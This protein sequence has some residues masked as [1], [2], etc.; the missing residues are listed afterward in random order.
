MKPIVLIIGLLVVGCGKQEQTTTE[1]PVK[2][3]TAEEKKVV[4]TY[5]H[6][7]TGTIAKQRLVF[8]E[9]GKVERGRSYGEDAEGK[10]S[11]V[12]GEIHIEWENGESFLGPLWLM[13][14]NTD[15][16]ITLIAHIRDGKRIAHGRERTHK[17]T[18]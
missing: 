6:E 14:V 7:F 18:K 11:V 12:D 13:R 3:L 10:W 2:E 17:K 9:N 15:T 8:Q 16:S 5:E 4:G 1:K